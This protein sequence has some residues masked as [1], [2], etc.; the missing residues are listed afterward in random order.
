MES[1]D[2]SSRSEQN[3]ISFPNYSVR[4]FGVFGLYYL[5]YSIL[6]SMSNHPVSGDGRLAGP[7]LPGERGHVPQGPPHR[8]R[9]QPHRGGP[10]RRLLH[11]AL[12]ERVRLP[13]VPRGH[14]GRSLQDGALPE[15]LLRPLQV[16]VHRLRAVQGILPRLLQEGA[17]G[18]EL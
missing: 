13:L 7:V 15:E 10:G 18:S 17:Q 9:R 3:S 12:R 4:P 5:H 2:T 11:G 8:P 14:G 16:Q 6:Q 1:F